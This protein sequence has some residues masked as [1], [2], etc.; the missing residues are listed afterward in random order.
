M[1]DDLLLFYYGLYTIPPE[2]LA[3]QGIPQSAKNHPE[4]DAYDHTLYV[5]KAAGII[6]SYSSDNYDE[7]RI[8][9]YAALCHDLGKATTTVVHEDG[10]ITSYD[11]DQEGVEPT[12]TLLERMNISQDIIDNVIPLVREHMA[13]VHIDKVTP[14]IVKRIA[15]RLL[16]S[17]IKMWS[18]LVRADYAGRPP[19]NPSIPIKAQNIID[20]ADSLGILNGIDGI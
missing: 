2:L 12:K 1:K 19:N 15:R 9:I 3:L 11:H 6:S 20:I 7:H 10:R 13:H 4:G 16:P 18:R 8:L 5:I 14:R 17:N